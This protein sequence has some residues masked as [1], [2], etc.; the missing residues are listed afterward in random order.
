MAAAH[1]VGF[2]PDVD[3]SMQRAVGVTAGEGSKALEEL[4]ACRVDGSTIGARLLRSGWP[5]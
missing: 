4:A 5:G 3:E 1:G 2:R